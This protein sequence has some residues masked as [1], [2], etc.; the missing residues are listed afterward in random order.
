MNSAPLMEFVECYASVANLVSMRRLATPV[1]VDAVYAIYMHAGVVPYLGYDPMPREDFQAVYDALLAS[2]NFYI[3]EVGGRV[4]GFYRITRYEGR[5][6][7]GAYLGTF[8]VAP[9]A[10]GTGLARRIIEDA[11]ARLRAEGIRRVE[12]Q[13]E[14][15]NPRAI[16]FYEKLGFVLEGRLHGAYKRASDRDYVDELQ[17]A[18]LLVS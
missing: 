5:A 3:V 18:R 10:Q 1:D 6:A 14:A 9:E 2:R 8:A 17:M 15:D 7:H 11:I 4:E 13:V 16:A 12:L